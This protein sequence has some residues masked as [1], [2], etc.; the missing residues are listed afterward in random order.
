[1]FMLLLE[2]SI[3]DMQKGFTNIVNHLVALGRHFDNK[4]LNIKILKILNRFWQPKVPTI[5]K[6]SDLTTMH[7]ITLFGKLI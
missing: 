4:E 3:Y 6:S 2:E 5:S 1:M 7:M